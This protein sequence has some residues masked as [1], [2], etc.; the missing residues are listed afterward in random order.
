MR[1]VSGNQ[2]LKRIFSSKQDDSHAQCKVLH[3]GDFREFYTFPGN[4][5]VIRIKGSTVWV[6]ETRNSQRVC[7]EKAIGS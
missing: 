7:G 5:M 4:F 3:N 2:M 6:R 1:C